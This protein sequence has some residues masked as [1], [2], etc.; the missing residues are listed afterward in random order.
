MVEVF[1]RDQIAN[2]VNDFRGPRGLSII[3][4]ND[5]HSPHHPFSIEFDAINL[6]FDNPDDLLSVTFDDVD[7]DSSFPKAV[8]LDNAVAQQ[9]VEF[10]FNHREQILSKTKSVW[11]SCRGGVSRSPAVAA[12]ILTICGADDWS[13]FN[14]GKYSPNRYVYEKLLETANVCLTKSAI[15]QKFAKNFEM[16]KIYNRG[17]LDV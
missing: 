14:N 7:L 8:L 4:I 15:D 16:W 11:V 3:C 10:A 13:I 17:N 2:N 9:I 5:N 6:K 12:A 1:S